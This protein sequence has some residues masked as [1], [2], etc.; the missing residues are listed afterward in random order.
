MKS[1]REKNINSVTFL[2]TTVKLQSYCSRRSKINTGHSKIKRK[3]KETYGK[4]YSYHCHFKITIKLHSN[5]QTGVYDYY[6]FTIT[7]QFTE[8]CM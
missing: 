8:K 4:V 6:H 3:L 5:L 1:A 2:K 7:Y